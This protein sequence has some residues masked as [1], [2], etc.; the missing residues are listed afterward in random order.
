M[1]MPKNGIFVNE[2][3]CLLQAPAVSLLSR[4]QAWSY[5]KYIFFAKKSLTKLGVAEIHGVNI[6]FPPSENPQ[7]L[8]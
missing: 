3:H 5:N 1:K 6:N 4:P 7:N 8:P 2:K